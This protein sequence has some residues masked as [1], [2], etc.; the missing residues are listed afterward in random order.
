[1]AELFEAITDG[2]IE[3][4][5]EDVKKLTQQSLDSGIAPSDILDKGLLPGHGYS[6]PEFR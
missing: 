5:L 3:G 4:K 6:G 1:M 2:V